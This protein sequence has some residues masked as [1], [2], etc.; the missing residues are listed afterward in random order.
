M[1]FGTITTFAQKPFAGKITF[2]TTAEGTNDPNVAAQLADMTKEIIIMGNNTKTVVNQMGVGVIN[3]TNGD[4]KMMTIVIDIPGYGKYFIE[5][6][7]PEIEKSFETVKMAYDYTAETKT[8]SGYECKKVNI[9]ITNLETDE[10]ASLVAWVTDALL[11]GDMVNF[12]T[13]PGLKGFPLS[14]EQKQ[15]INGEMLTIIETAT[16]VTPNKKVKSTD[17]LRPSDATDIKEAPDDLKQ[18]FGIS[19]EE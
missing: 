19:N 7:G 6:D 10:E 18:M 8:I 5:K 16:A 4:Y 15:E 3:I 9:T 13:Y 12:C 2:E 14:V 11:T 17:F 1:L